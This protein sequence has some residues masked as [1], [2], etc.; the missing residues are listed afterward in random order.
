[1][2][3]RKQV[4]A[5]TIKTREQ[6]EKARRDGVEVIFDDPLPHARSKSPKKR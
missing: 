2:A 5:S 4:K 1:M 6:F 3:K